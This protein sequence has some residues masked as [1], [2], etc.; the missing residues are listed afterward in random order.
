[1]A[2]L[3][4]VRSGTEVTLW[5]PG[6]LCTYVSDCYLVAIAENTSCLASHR[7]TSTVSDLTVQSR[8]QP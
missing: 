6:C 8:R 2:Y 1:M 7:T 5:S 3:V 4:T